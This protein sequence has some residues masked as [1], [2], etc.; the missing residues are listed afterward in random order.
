MDARLQYENHAGE[1]GSDQ[2]HMIPPKS[3]GDDINC[4]FYSPSSLHSL[5]DCR[6]GTIQSSL[7]LSHSSP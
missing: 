5:S 6:P 3:D 4:C 2:R 7:T 1:D